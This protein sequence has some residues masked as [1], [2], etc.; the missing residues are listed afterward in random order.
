MYHDALAGLAALGR[1]LHGGGGKPGELLLHVRAEAAVIGL[2][3]APDHLAPG[4]GTA[5]RGAARGGIY[6]LDNVPGT[7]NHMP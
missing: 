3:H 5:R 4:R 7:F 1:S 2:M 6:H